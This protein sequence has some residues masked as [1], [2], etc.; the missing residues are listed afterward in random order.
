ML[1]TAGRRKA[2][3]I[4]TAMNTTHTIKGWQDRLVGLPEQRQTVLMNVNM[5]QMRYEIIAD[6]KPHQH[7]IINDSLHT[8]LERQPRLNQT[9]SRSSVN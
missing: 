6:K 8:V 7:P 1:S 2:L 5:R 4:T 3:C 9:S